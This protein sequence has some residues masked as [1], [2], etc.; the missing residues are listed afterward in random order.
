MF[1]L[2]GKTVVITGASSG[3]GRECAITCSRAGAQL[4]LLGR[5]EARLEETHQKL[6]G[7][8]HLMIRGD[9]TL[10]DSMETVVNG[11]HDFVEEIHGLVHAAGVSP[12]LPFRISSR[13]K[14]REAFEINVFAGY[15][16]A[17]QL[18]KQS[19]P[20]EGMMSLVFI[21][22]VMG[23]RGEKAK[24]IYGMTKGALIAGCK[25]LSVELADK[26]IRVNTISPGVVETPMSAVS[27]YRKSKEVMEEVLRKHPLG[28]GLPEDVA[29]SVLFLLS[30]EARHITGHDL[31]VDGGY[32]AM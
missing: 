27:P 1:C 13:R 8:G 7:D 23:S 12:A 14:V 11:I 25:S 26:N 18:V 21:A 15:E 32:T 22:S 6:N 16:L 4:I 3:I 9:L 10:E 2:K 28:L 24:S 19:K 29:A 20:I 17:R 30:D 5:D 31:R